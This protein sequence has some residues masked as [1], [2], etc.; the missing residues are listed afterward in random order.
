M[1][2]IFNLVLQFFLHL[3]ITVLIYIFCVIDA[4]SE[5]KSLDTSCA[6][7]QA[8]AQSAEDESEVN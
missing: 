5:E 6:L 1:Y 8:A 7:L 3:L 2:R 4:I